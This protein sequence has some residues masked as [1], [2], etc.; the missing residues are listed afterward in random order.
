ML[1][2]VEPANEEVVRGEERVPE[3]A[4]AKKSGGKR[5]KKGWA[6]ALLAVV[7]VGAAGL[8]FTALSSQTTVTVFPRWREPT[9]NSVFEAKR[10]ASGSELAY[11]VMTLEAT[12][13]REVTATGQE[14]VEEQAVGQIT[15]FN[16]SSESQRLIT[17]TRFESA[18]GLIFRIKD[19][20]VAPP[21]TPE[22]PGTVVAE[23]F[24]DQAGPEYNL[25]AGTRFTV[26]GLQGSDA[27]NTIHAENTLAMTGGHRG[28]KFIIDDAE[29][30]AATESLRS[31]LREALQNRIGSE[32]PAGFVVFDA[33]IRYAYQALP[34]EEVGNG[35][36]KI[37]EKVLLQ[38][39]IFK[40]EDFAAFIA[41][42]T[43]PGYESEPVRIEN[44][45][46]LTFEY[47]AEPNLSSEEPISFKL[48]GRPKIIWTYDVEQ[49]KRDLA[50]G[51]QTAL[52]TVLGGYPAIERATAT[53]KPFWR[54]SFPEDA[55]DMVVVENLEES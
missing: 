40:N 29:L 37:K 11:E 25:P 49:L 27:F 33:A 30:Q 10:Q 41:A 14:E 46:T 26:P 38:L 44:L 52:N 50:G 23:V 53:I 19:P 5:P 24:A 16:T 36:V 55:N 51:S 12:G 8:A 15:I 48:L 7:V 2:R 43:V 6:V 54:R 13:E 18:G 35:R 28:P 45:S 4:P 42:A 32:K 31:E 9:V 34:A 22:E 20:A 21:G 3:R 1:K 47:A 39:P 17:N